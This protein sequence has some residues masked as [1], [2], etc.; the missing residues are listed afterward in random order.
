[1]TQ[2]DARAE[3]RKLR[4]TLKPSW[5]FAIA[6]GSAVG[7]GALILPLEW[8]GQ[9]GTAGALIGF[10]LGALLIAIIAVSYGVVIRVLPVTGGELAFTLQSFG[11]RAAFVVGWFLSLA[12]ACI[13][14]LNASAIA[15][16]CR[17]LFPEVMER[18]HLY[19][20][21]GWDIYLPEVLVALA[22][23]VITGL[24][25]AAGTP[26]SGRFQFIA[27]VILIA[28]I[29]LILVGSVVMY[30]MNPVPLYRAFPAET[31][32]IAAIAVMI[33]F[34]PWA[35]V[36]FDNVPQAAGEF[37][38]APG[39]AMGLILAAIATAG[40]V[41]LAM[42]LSASIA[43]GT[44]GSTYEGSVWATADAIGGLLGPAG[45]LLMVVA[46]SMGVITGLNGFT[47]SASRLIMTMGRARML[48][49]AVGRVSARWETPVVAIVVTV[50]LCSPSPFF[51]RSAL[52]WIVDMT[53]VGVTVAYGATCLVAY[54]LAGGP[55]LG[56]T[57]TFGSRRRPVRMVAVLGAV[58]SVGFLLL[59]V[60]PFSPGALGREPFIALAIWVAL[61]VVFYLARRRAVDALP[62]ETMRKVILDG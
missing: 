41:Y 36:G 51:G 22:A 62:E 18:G 8:L 24:L 25:N 28:A 11:R 5:V 23:L 16:V 19:T 40:A 53:S 42:I 59:L 32:P 9:G 13:V 12:Y 1:M 33:A 58:I 61:G 26:I 35:F 27:C 54:R 21:A 44:T 6:L 48:P 39:K 30:V 38:F 29:A 4:Q 50:I 14:A 60:L 15:L 46:V 49:T 45:R 31:S 56:D 52:L 2:A 47:V 7:W 20:V 55:Q 34:A 57:G 17:M 3:T 10:L 37:D 43:V